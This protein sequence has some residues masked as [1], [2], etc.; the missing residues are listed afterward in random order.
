MEIRRTLRRLIED[1]F[2]NLAVLSFQELSS[3]TGIQAIGRISWVRHV[4]S[5][6]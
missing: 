5:A 1:D 6:A 2:P 4:I 3:D